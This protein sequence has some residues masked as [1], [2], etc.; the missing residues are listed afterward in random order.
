MKKTIF[1]IVL[2]VALLAGVFFYY[3]TTTPRY[4]LLKTIVDVKEEGA[5]GLRPHLTSD[6]ASL[7]DK[8]ETL[9]SNDWVS[10][11]LSNLTET[12]GVQFLKTKMS[13]IQWS[14]DDVM[15]GKNSA[16]AVVRFDY[17]DTVSGTVK[18]NMVRQDRVWL[19]SG[20]EL[21]HFDKLVLTDKQ[22]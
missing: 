1:A 10:I 5:D 11:I 19:I 18:L 17:E 3:Q 4:A 14:L 12:D 15:A 8:I 22:S 16:V 13:E 9:T 6:A 20:I 2:I 21:P 7:F